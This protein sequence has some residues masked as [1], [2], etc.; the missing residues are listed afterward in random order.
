MIVHSWRCICFIVLCGFDQNYD[1]SNWF[2]NKLWNKRIE[3][4]K[5]RHSLSLFIWPQVFFLFSCIVKNQ[6]STCWNRGLLILMGYGI[7]PPY[8]YKSRTRRFRF[9]KPCP[10]SVWLP[11]PDDRSERDRHALVLLLAFYS[12]HGRDNAPLWLC[13]TTRLTPRPPR[14]PCPFVLMEQRRRRWLLGPCSGAQLI[15]SWLCRPRA[16]RGVSSTTRRP[17]EALHPPSHEPLFRRS[18]SRPCVHERDQKTKTRYLQNCHSFVISTVYSSNSDLIC[19]NYVRF[20]SSRSTQLNKYLLHNF[21]LN[22][23][24]WIQFVYY[25][26]NSFLIKN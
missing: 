12:S 9:A 25:L 5:S 4:K 22:L 23:F 8:L 3:K 21:L 6:V 11:P 10:S 24:I 1:N 7:S 13:C 26:L 17:A 16:T 19:S 15:Y 18:I 2:W 20:V 14:S